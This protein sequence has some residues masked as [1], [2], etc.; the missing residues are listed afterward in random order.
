MKLSSFAGPLAASP[1]GWW[2]KAIPFGCGQIIPSASYR[3]NMLTTFVGP[4]FAF[5]PV[6]IGTK[7]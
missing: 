2:S 1:G 7:P 6:S 3:I 5:I 4:R